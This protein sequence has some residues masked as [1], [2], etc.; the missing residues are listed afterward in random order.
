[1][2]T[3]DRTAGIGRLLMA[4]ALFAVLAVPAAKD[5]HAQTLGRP[6]AIAARSSEAEQTES[7]WGVAGAAL[8][9][10]E[11]RLVRVAPEIGMNP[12]ALAAGIG[13]CLLAMIDAAA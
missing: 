4:L 10:F 3:A 13:G 11:I 2:K 9:G 8:C 1:M 12:Y 5:L 6:G 7:W